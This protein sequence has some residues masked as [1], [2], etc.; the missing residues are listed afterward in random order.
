MEEKTKAYLEIA[1]EQTINCDDGYD[2]VFTREMVQR[3][4]EGLGTE[5]REVVVLYYMEG[6]SV[7]EI[8]EIL[9]IGT[10]NV[11]SKLFRARKKLK[12]IMQQ[13]TT[14]KEDIEYIINEGTKMDELQ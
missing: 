9:S 1:R 13:G 11:K 7:A 8:T 14:S 6:K 12:E 10:E 4:V 5:L 3:A 2:A